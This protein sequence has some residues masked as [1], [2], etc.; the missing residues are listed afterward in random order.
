MA[1]RRD[2]AALAGVSVAT[3]SY[4]MNHTK[5]VT[6]E[7]QARVEAAI[8]ELHYTPNLVAK[9]LA[10]RKTQHVVMLVNNLKNPHYTE[11]LAGAQN[12][13]SKRGYIVSII[14]I[15]NA[16]PE[17]ALSL[18][19]RGINGV[20][21]AT[22]QPEETTRL[23]D[24]SIPCVFVGRNIDYDY[25]QAILD[26]VG[27]LKEHGHQHIAFLSGLQLNPETNPRYRCLQE[28]LIHYG[29]P[30]DAQLMVGGIA[31][32]ENDEEAGIL[33]MRALLAR[34]VPFTAVLTIND[35]MAFGAQ[36]E[37]Y[38]HHLRVPEDISVIGCD[39]IKAGEYYTPPLSTLNVSA[40]EMGRFLMKDLI[41]RIEHRPEMRKVIKV[42]YIERESVGDC[43]H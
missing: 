41:A 16:N 28:A 2:V 7:V 11:M 3:V 30:C 32:E 29:L 36:S 21:V 27:S 19:A 26:A 38:R 9:G 10:T 17:G 6:P 22:D 37:L 8:Q 18:T 43:T 13:A 15:D 35:L 20:I 25:H 39:N 31:H 14:M 33:A 4:V 42:A 40:F 5:N 1:T 34:E 12:V 24:G 23:L